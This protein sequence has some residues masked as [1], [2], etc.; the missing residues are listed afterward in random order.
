MQVHECRDACTVV[1]DSSCCRQLSALIN[2][3]T[4]ECVCIVV[5]RDLWKIIQEI[6]AEV[7]LSVRTVH[8]ILHKNVNVFWSKSTLPSTMWL[9]SALCFPV[10]HN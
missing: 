6:A 9:V 5:R 3:E 7:I 2:D 10:L 8:N 1:S 4:I